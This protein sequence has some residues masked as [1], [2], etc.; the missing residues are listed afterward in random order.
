[1]LKKRILYFL[2]CLIILLYFFLRA[3]IVSVMLISFTL[4]LTAFSAVCAATVSKKSKFD[5]SGPEKLKTKEVGLV[6]VNMENKSCLP[7]MSGSVL[8][9]SEIMSDVEEVE[10]LN[11]GFYLGSK[12]KDTIEV[13]VT[14]N[15][16]GD[17]QV[18]MDE[19]RIMDVFGVFCFKTKP[20]T[21]NL[22]KIIVEPDENREDVTNEQELVSDNKEAK[23]EYK[24]ENSTEQVQE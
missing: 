14:S 6:L 5:I 23:T 11:V 10:K 18:S 15:L 1:M 17:I 16:S 12:N 9:S 19:I 13:E 20:E 3:D 2:W 21:D 24:E 7:I 4:I 22:I 8:L